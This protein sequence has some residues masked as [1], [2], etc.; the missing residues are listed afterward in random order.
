MQKKHTHLFYIG[1]LMTAVGAILFFSRVRIGSYL[2]P[3]FGSFDTAP[4][5]VVAWAL[6]FLLLVFR[7]SSMAKYLLALVTLALVIAVILSAHIYFVQTSI[8]YFFG[9]LALLFG[10]VG[11]VLRERNKK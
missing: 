11:L 10:G 3:R 6:C 5:F 8:L 9:I 7:P 1:L 4:V 2:F